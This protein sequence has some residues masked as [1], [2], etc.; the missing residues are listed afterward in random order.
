MLKSLMR[1]TYQVSDTEKAKQWYSDILQTP[2][3]FDTPFA[4]I[5]QVGQCTL[6]LVKGNDPLPEPN[7]RVEVYWD[8]DDIE[9]VYK[10]LLEK[11]AV[12]QSPI[13]SI[14]N[15]NV[16][17]VCDPFGNII[18]LTSVDA[19][20]DKRKVEDAPSETAM[21]V[22]FCRALAFADEREGITGSD[23]MAH[24]FL[25][26]GSKKI[27]ADANARKKAREYMS[28]T[29]MYGYF[30]AR[31]AYVDSVF[32]QACRDG[33][34]QI[35]FLGAGYDTRAYRYS[36][37]L[38]EIRVFEL[39]IRST[40]RK[41][42]AD[43]ENAGIPIPAGVSFVEINF[44][45]DRLG[46]VLM[47]AGYDAAKRTL[48]IWEGVMYY[49]TESAVSETLKFIRQNSPADSCVCFDSL[50]YKLTSINPSE[51]FLF[52]MT[53]ADMND[54]LSRNGCELSETLDHI[55]IEKQFLTSAD[56]VVI[57]H[58]IPFFCFA[59]ARTKQ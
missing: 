53:S 50:T 13:R 51:P 7:D 28:A 55:A 52:W 42:I 24:I 31:T 17:K 44:K 18:G 4:A 21:N 27:L 14:L 11:G 56:G 30:T 37:L 33:I 23:S 40:Q 9:T 22:C 58:S 16:A 3:I 46:D 19:G 47:R 34:Q 48:F 36:D 45:T 35:V 39:D 15:I 57:E 2:P 49:L 12:E 1:I 32:T 6:S 29:R 41:K 20:A 59:R 25:N 43:L 10:T 26:E 5:F 54:F 8:V 38:G